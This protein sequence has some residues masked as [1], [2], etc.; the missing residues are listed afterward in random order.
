MSSDSKMALFEMGDGLMEQ[1]T[2][3]GMIKQCESK[4]AERSRK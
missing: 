1:R 4:V 3:K 2:K